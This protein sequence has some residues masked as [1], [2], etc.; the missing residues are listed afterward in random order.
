MLV[1]H[2]QEKSM[3]A[4][5]GA[6]RDVLLEISTNQLV[7]EKDHAKMNWSSYTRDF[8]LDIKR[9]TETNKKAPNR[10]SI[11]PDFCMTLTVK[12]HINLRDDIKKSVITGS[13]IL[14]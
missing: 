9:F 8:G 14:P 6:A 5:Q 13:G 7:H 10:K 1:F 3:V 11:T 2:L 4:F 12:L